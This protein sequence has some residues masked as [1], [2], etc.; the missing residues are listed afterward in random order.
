MYIPESF[1]SGHAQTPVCL[2]GGIRTH[3]LLRCTED[4]AEEC[5][6]QWTGTARTG[7]FTGQKAHC[8]QTAASNE[9]ASVPKAVRQLHGCAQA[10]E[11]SGAAGKSALNSGRVWRL[12]Q[13]SG[14][15]PTPSTG[16][17]QPKNP[18]Q[19]G[20]ASTATWLRIPADKSYAGH[21]TAASR[22][23]T[24]FMYSQGEKTHLTVMGL[25]NVSTKA[26][27]LRL[28]VCLSGDR[29]RFSWARSLQQSYCSGSTPPKC[30]QGSRRV[31]G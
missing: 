23:K 24:R 12:L 21:C 14:A 6:R 17:Q 22:G 27:Y 13:S 29:L 16:S 10:A 30:T 11:T 31:P 9:A 19:H 15:S 18:H 2:L 8:L 4:L 3:S 26:L 25:E 1:A 7:T 28:A 20:R 5:F